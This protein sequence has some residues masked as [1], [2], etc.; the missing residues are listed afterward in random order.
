MAAAAAPEGAAADP[1]LPTRLMTSGPDAASA[2]AASGRLVGVGVSKTLDPVTLLAP[3]DAASGPGECLVV[4]G[5]N[6]SGKTTLLRIMAG[7]LDPTTGSVH[8]G[9][10]PVDERDPACRKEIA[11]LL[12][13]PATYPDLT[14]ADH[15]TLIDAT[16]GGA[17]D[18]CA[19]RVDEALAD[20]EIDHLAQRFPHELSSGQNQLF[21]LALTLFRP[22][23]VLVLDEP[24]QRLD[25]DKRRLVGELLVARRQHGA[26]LV[27]ACH[28]PELTE[29]IATEV[30]DIEA[31]P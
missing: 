4:R 25:T 15:L 14:L 28:D 16:W 10:L 21:R 2:P 23:G 13:A 8:L 1:R 24:E 9:R 26:A 11:A 7:V 17:V 27:V 22:S 6:G 18:T 29:H 19:D 31:A 5:R 30:L 3:V 20:L 12:G